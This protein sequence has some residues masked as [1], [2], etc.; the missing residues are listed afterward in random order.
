MHI[1][2]GRFPGD[3][4]GNYTCIANNGAS[5]VDY[6]ICSTELFPLCS[7]FNV[8]D[9]TESVHFP[10]HSKFILKRYKSKRIHDEA[11]R[12]HVKY[13]WREDKSETFFNTFVNLFNDKKEEICLLARHNLDASIAMFTEIF[14]K[15][16]S[17]MKSRVKKKLF[18]QQPEWWDTECDALKQRKYAA[19]RKFRLTNSQH[20]LQNQFKDMLKQKNAKR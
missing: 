17:P 7:D 16:A 2:N 12:Q 9:R 8:D 4:K 1:M 19:L 14:H 20:D 15:A 5:V 11:T 6:H 3:S 13:K 10:I 18:D